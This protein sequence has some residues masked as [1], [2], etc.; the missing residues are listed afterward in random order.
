MDSKVLAEYCSKS[1]SSECRFNLEESQ[2][3]EY[4]S[5]EY[6]YDT[7]SLFIKLRTGE[8]IFVFRGTD[9]FVDN[10]FNI[11][12]CRIKK[13]GFG[14][15]RGFYSKWK[16][17]KWD[18]YRF[19]NKFQNI[20]N[21]IFT[22]HSLGGAISI[23]GAF[24]IKKEYPE[25]KVACVTFG[26]PRIGSKSF[27][28]EFN[29]IIDCS[30]RYTYRYD[31]I[32]EVPFGFKHCGLHMPI[33]NVQNIDLEPEKNKF[34]KLLKVIFTKKDFDHSISNYLEYIPPHISIS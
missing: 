18:I 25:M 10:I 24:E 8:L 6:G 1:Y 7:E 2:V 16:K 11:Q 21:I 29:R 13:D 23:I 26:C 33:Y 30:Q 5:K 31:H 9:S 27:C 15:H 17:V 20:K 28:D 14:I 3:E 22:G 34:W 19:I 32:P 12:A 4:E